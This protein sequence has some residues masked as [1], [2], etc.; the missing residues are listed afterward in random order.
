[1][2]SENIPAVLYNSNCIVDV[3]HRVKSGK[4]ADVYCCEAH[5]YLG[6]KL[7]AVK[8]YRSLEARGFRNDNVYQQGRFIKDSRLRRAYQNKSRA[9]RHTQFDLWV[10]AEY[11]TLKL[12]HSAGARVPKP[13]ESLG[14]AIVMEY[15]GSRDD[16]APSLN[17]VKL[18]KEE[19]RQIREELL[20]QVQLWLS[21]GRIHADLS[22]Y[23][24]LY[25]EG[26][27]TVIDFPQSV[28]LD[29]NPAS[30]GLLLRDFEHIAEYFE[31]LD[32]PLDPFKS[33]RRIWN[34]NSPYKV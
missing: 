33:A 28:N 6:V 15:I 1:M 16:P 26:A 29:Q 23:N 12:L 8:V 20:Q 18:S 7:L 10:S 32:L 21:C 4:E 13:Y 27:I 5:A 31:K 11:E 34:A 30:F 14:S 24:I 17:R 3:L 2:E 22:P 19:A 9:G 25:M